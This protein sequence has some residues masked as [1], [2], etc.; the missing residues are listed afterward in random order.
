MRNYI[1]TVFS[2]R[3]I[4]SFISTPSVFERAELYY[5]NKENYMNDGNKENYHEIHFMVT[6]STVCNHSSFL[7]WRLWNREIP[8]N[9]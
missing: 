9:V 2:V 4:F 5:G 8:L 1:P 6:L 3:S 7:F